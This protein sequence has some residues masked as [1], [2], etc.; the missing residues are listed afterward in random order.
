MNQKTI[1]L[2]AGGTGGHLFPAIAIAESLHE[3]SHHELH[4]ITDL[5]CQK[6]LTSDIPVKT[7][8]VDLHLKFNNILN[9]F[10]IPFQILIATVK[11]YL[12][13]RKIKPDI[14]IGFG[15]YPSFPAMLICKF[16]NID[17]VL[18]EQNSYF[19]KVNQF[20]ASYA[21]YICLAYQNTTQFDHAYSHKAQLIGYVVR[22]NIKQISKKCTFSNKIFRLF[23][24][25][26]SQ[27]AQIFSKLVPEAI[28]IL[29]H[30]YPNTQIEI[31]QQ[32]ADTDHE[33]IKSIYDSLHVKYNIAAFFHN[34][35]SIYQESDLVISRSGASTIA[36]LSTIGL[37]AIFIP[38]PAAADNHQYY[39]AKNLA[40]IDASWCFQQSQITPEILA[41]QIYKLYKDRALLQSASKKLLKTQSDGSMQLSNIVLKHLEQK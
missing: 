20:F 4:L 29:L 10:K 15:G 12:Q 31:T 6:Y 16:M 19:G 17:M 8:I 5:R 22:R 7:S 38:F 41:S 28:S 39:N 30:K 32:V 1:L 26:G 27:S 9:K 36:E 25:G 24:F 18:H 13:V 14:V 3:M 35:E 11:A 40:D 37:P 21:K 23:I 34:M 33:T 2:V